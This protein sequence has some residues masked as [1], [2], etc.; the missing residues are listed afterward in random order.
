M[1]GI[2][3]SG[4]L[5]STFAWD[6]ERLYDDA[7][8]SAGPQPERLRGAAT[9]VGEESA[10]GS[11]RILR[12]P[13]GINK[14]FWAREADGG[15]VFSS[16]PWRLVEAG[17]DLSQ[18]FAVPRG[19]VTDIDAADPEARLARSLLPE[20]WFDDPGNGADVEAI[21][22]EI[23][24]LLDRYL[25]AI[26]AQHGSAEIFVC[27]SGG[28]D[29]SGITAL[30]ADHFPGATAVSFDIARP[31]GG[32]SEDRTTAQ[33][34]ARDLH[35]PLLEVTVTPEELLEPLDVVLREGIDW[36][37][38][39]VHAAL[40]NAALAKEVAEVAVRDG[41][42]PIVFT[43]DLANEFLIDYHAEEYRGE[44][45]YALPRLKPVDLRAFLVRGL[46]TSHREVGVFGAW[47]LRLVQPYAVAVDA[48]MRLPEDFL[49]LPDR[50]DRLC[51]AT[52]GGGVPE[53]VFTR[54]KTRAQVGDE[55]EGG[56][57]AMCVDRGIDSAVLRRRFC[58]LHGGTEERALD[59]FIRAGRYRA[60][61]PSIEQPDD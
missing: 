35:M 17:Y 42:S 32:V 33:R 47:N 2:R 58:E 9:V 4:E 60:K 61:A 8:L 19:L 31:G 6:G 25:E 15:I 34:V 27:L 43:G 45:Y 40:V 29:S 3:L 21:G 39:N 41:A 16:R 38:F 28:L 52:F 37:D 57:L 22:G 23:R 54:P 56:V 44:T 26:A 1:T 10:D 5:E 48:Y 14:L 49:R 18:I 55:H 13:L 59:R 36:R 20:E 24:E 11:R 53:Y 46:D 7:E 30:V 51:R 12:D 50:K